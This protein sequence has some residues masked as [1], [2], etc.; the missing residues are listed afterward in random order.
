MKE[1][2]DNKQKIKEE[3][4]FHIAMAS[5]LISILA[6]PVGVYIAFVVHYTYDKEK[7]E[8]AVI[9]SLNDIH[10]DLELG[11]EV[12]S[13]ESES[14]SL[15]EPNA[16]KNFMNRLSNSPTSFFN[17]TQS[18]CTNCFKAFDKKDFSVDHLDQNLYKRISDF[19]TE[20][21]YLTKVYDNLEKLIENYQQTHYRLFENKLMSNGTNT[22]IITFWEEQLKNRANAVCLEMEE[23]KRYTEIENELSSLVDDLDDEITRRKGNLDAEKEKS[24][25]SRLE[26]G[27]GNKFKGD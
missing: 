1:A 24:F 25:P 18:V 9:R 21:H 22:A 5:L 13:L 27:F 12:L 16:C 3:R 6:V 10:F 15:F 11:L 17:L 19:Y 23:T 7:E 2:S 4:K 8:E 14:L 20:I 26:W